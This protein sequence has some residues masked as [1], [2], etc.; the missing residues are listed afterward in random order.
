M[1]DELDTSADVLSKLS[2]SSNETAS[3]AAII[4]AEVGQNEDGQE[5]QEK[6]RGK[7]L[8]DGDEGAGGGG[9]PKKDDTPKV[10]RGL[11]SSACRPVW[12]YGCMCACVHVYVCQCML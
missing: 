9:K 12:I 3:E 1:G 7:K 5:D 11:M 8:A 10:S 2:L 6:A 4:D